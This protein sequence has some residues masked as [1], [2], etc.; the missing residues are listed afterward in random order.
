[1]D[2]TYILAILLYVVC[3]AA[4]LGWICLWLRICR[5]KALRIPLMLIAS[6]GVVY[7]AARIV[8]L[9]V[10]ETYSYSNICAQGLLLVVFLQFFAPACI[11]ALIVSVCRAIADHRAAPD[12]SGKYKETFTETDSL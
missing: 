9:P 2:D 5:G 1:M 7:I 4:S 11:I 6:L 8:F 3:G 10:D 12:N